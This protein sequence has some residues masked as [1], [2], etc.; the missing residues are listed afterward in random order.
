MHFYLY[1]K[2]FP[3]FHIA[4]FKNAGVAKFLDKFH[5]QF[6]LPNGS[7]IIFEDGLLF[8]RWALKFTAK[9]VMNIY[10]IYSGRY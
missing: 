4:F 8:T 3:S 10:S 9:I 5:S 7:L 1:K 6:V 2:A